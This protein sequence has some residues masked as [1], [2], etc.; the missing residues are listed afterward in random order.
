MQSRSQACLPLLNASSDYDHFHFHKDSDLHLQA[1]GGKHLDGY[2]FDGSREKL[3]GLKSLSK[4]QG[5]LDIYRSLESLQRHRRE[6]MRKNERSK[7]EDVLPIFRQLGHGS[8]T[9]SLGSVSSSITMTG[10]R[11]FDDVGSVGTNIGNNDELVEE[12]AEEVTN[13]CLIK[14]DNSML[15][16]QRSILSNRSNF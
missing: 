6:L 4:S 9:T 3:Y 14:D 2:C 5:M 12:Q 16:E 7:T 15:S 11:D 1:L 8:S 13:I 10:A